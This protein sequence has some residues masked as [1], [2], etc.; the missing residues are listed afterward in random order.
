MYIDS[1]MLGQATVTKTNI[2]FAITNSFIISIPA[3]RERKTNECERKENVRGIDGA[4][5]HMGE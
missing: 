4:H 2:V 5:T 3:G 1:L